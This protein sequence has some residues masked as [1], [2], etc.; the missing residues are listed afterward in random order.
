MA[1]GTLSSLS[2]N[3]VTS[4]SSYRLMTS[5]GSLYYL[6]LTLSRWE[7]F[8]RV[9]YVGLPVCWQMQLAHWHSIQATYGKSVVDSST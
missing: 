5:W 6:F 8:P 7:E 2:V 9:V 3:L 1:E 4:C